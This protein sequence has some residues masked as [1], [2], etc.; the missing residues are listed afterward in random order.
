MSRPSSAPRRALVSWRK[1]SSGTRRNC[2]ACPTRERKKPRAFS[3]PSFTSAGSSSSAIVLK[4]TVAT[5][6]SPLTSTALTRAP[7][8]RGSLTSLISNSFTSRWIS[9]P[10][11]SFLEYSRDISADLAGDLGPLV[12]LD[13]IAGLHV[14]V[15]ANADTA[16]RPGANFADVVLE[17]AQRLERAFEDHDVVAEHADRIAAAHVAVHD[18]ATRDLPELRRS[19]D[20]TNLGQPH[21][22]L[23]NLRSKQ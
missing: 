3:N 10:T 20:L 17:T 9:A 16:L 13:L 21:D 12:A 22:L 2:S 18:H 8:R 15:I 5:P 7:L 11:L 23:A 6:K 19:E 4:K 14:V 1:R